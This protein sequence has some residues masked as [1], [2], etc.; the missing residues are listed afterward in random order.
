[1]RAAVYYG[2]TKLEIEE[3]PEPPVGPGQ[4]VGISTAIATTS[5]QSG[6]IGVGFAITI[7][8]AMSTANSLLSGA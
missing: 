4:V 6:S 7:D 1:M 8:D 3:V 5:A 2:N